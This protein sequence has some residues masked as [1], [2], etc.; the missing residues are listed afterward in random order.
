MIFQDPLSSL[1]PVFTIGDQICGVIQI[2][3]KM[4]RKHAQ[5]RAVE[6][7]SMVRLPNPNRL[8]KKYP[9]ELSGGQLQRIM[10]A[11]AL[12]CRPELLIA[13]EPTT[14]LDVT[15]QA[16]ILTLMLGLKEKTKTSIMLITHDLG[17][18]AEICDRVAIMYAGLIVEEAGINDIFLRPLHPYTEGLMAAIPGRGNRGEDLATIKGIVPNL[19]DL[20]KGCRFH[21]RCPLAEEI[22]HREPPRL[23]GRHNGRKLACHM[24]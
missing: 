18:V 1:N 20:P 12:S 22:C 11:M 14:A 24:R 19:I 3:Q 13:D 5:K 21:P 6:M 4:D 8:L 17:V 9:H 23:S 15:I 10:I 16:Q 7:F 2:H